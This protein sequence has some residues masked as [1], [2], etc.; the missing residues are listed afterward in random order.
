[1]NPTFI[2]P[3]PEEKSRVSVFDPGEILGSRFESLELLS[4]TRRVAFYLGRDGDEL[5]VV[6][7]FT[8]HS[9]QQLDLF[10]LETSTAAKLSHP[11]VVKAN[12]PQ[13]TY[14]VHFSIIEHHSNAETLK[15]LL[16]RE[17][18]LDPRFGPPICS[19]RLPMPW[20]TPTVLASCIWQF[21]LR[22]F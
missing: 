3:I 18:W 20:T 12:P 9:E 15:E 16:D 4:A 2:S 7:V 13:E 10:Q 19:V 11:N 22:L 1:M 5:V 17:G 14:G 6:K 8:G 21:S